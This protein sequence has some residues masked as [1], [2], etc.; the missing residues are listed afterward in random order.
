MIFVFDADSTGVLIATLIVI[1]L[2]IGFIFVRR[3][4]KKDEKFENR[5]W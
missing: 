4:E 1:A 3:K 5:K 2:I